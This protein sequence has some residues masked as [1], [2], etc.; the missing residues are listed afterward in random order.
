[1]I[2]HAL[3]QHSL[4]KLVAVFKEFLNNII[5]KDIRHKLQSVGVDFTEDLV[6]FITICRLEFLLD[7]SR[8]VLVATEF[9]DMFV[10]VLFMLA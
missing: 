5:A 9:Y 8:P 1:M 6:L 3:C 4:L 2:L 7:E 10:D